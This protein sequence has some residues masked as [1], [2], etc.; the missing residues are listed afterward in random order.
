MT[1][2]TCNDPNMKQL[3]GNDENHWFSGLNK[4]FI[5]ELLAYVTITLLLK[6][7]LSFLL[8]QA[9]RENYIAYCYI[10][11]VHISCNFLQI[12]RWIKNQSCVF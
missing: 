6:I 10:E 11:P 1:E 3:L 9:G 5:K 2:L 12:T 7:T 4:I 8:L